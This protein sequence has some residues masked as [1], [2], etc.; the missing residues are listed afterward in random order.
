M[1]IFSMKSGTGI[2]N[3]K[4]HQKMCSAF[5]VTNLPPPIMILS[6]MK[7]LD[8]LKVFVSKQKAAHFSLL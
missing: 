2:N 5:E 7:D 6:D 1:A 3:C 8:H 4:Q